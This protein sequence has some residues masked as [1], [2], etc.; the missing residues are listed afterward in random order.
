MITLFKLDK[1]K[2]LASLT[3]EE[4]LYELSTLE[5]IYDIRQLKALVDYGELL[6]PIYSQD[7]IK[8]EQIWLEK[9]RVWAYATPTE[10]TA[11]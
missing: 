2:I 1:E 5:A 6:V 8:G 9:Y 7:H 11:A 4:E 10:V 3:D